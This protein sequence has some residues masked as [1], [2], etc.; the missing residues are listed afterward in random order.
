MFGVSLAKDE[1][2]QA[3]MIETLTEININE[4]LASSN[5]SL[6]AVPK[7]FFELGTFKVVY[8]LEVLYKYYFRFTILNTIYLFLDRDLH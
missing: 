7:L 4:T 3:G 6:L 5:S 1:S 8:R 2:S